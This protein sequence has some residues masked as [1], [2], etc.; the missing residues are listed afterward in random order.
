M[1]EHSDKRLDVIATAVEDETM[2]EWILEDILAA[3]MDGGKVALHHYDRPDARLKSDNS[4][5]TDADHA[6]ERDLDARFNHPEAGSYLI[7]EETVD[8]KSESYI[9]DAF[10]NVAYIVDPID[11]TAC[12]AHHIPTWGI[13]IARMERGTITDGGVYLPVTG[14]VFITDGPAILYAAIQGKRITVEDLKPLEIVHRPPD[15]R[16]MIA[17]TQSVVKHGGFSLDNPVQALACAVVALTYLLLDRYTAY[18][19]TLKLWDIAACLAFL[20]RAGF[21]CVYENG[22][23]IGNDVTD[24]I[25]NLEPNHPRRWYMKDKMLCGATPA[26][27][28]YLQKG[29]S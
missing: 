23:I 12:Y 9:D 27:V 19:G 21:T 26:A 11:G 13:S 16:G 18:M 7:G 28:E 8:T 6:I 1:R 5:V 10:A 25:Y 3:L 14:E 29:L 22:T 17:V 4:I 24:T 20:G 2:K 15:V